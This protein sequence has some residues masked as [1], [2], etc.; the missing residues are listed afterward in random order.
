M[1]PVLCA[2]RRRREEVVQRKGLIHRKLMK[3]KE[4]SE[5]NQVMQ[6]RHETKLIFTFPTLP[7]FLRSRSTFILEK[8][9]KYRVAQSLD[10]EEEIFL[11]EF[12]SK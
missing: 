6:Y 2:W 4:E 12:R 11:E 9:S 8:K 1:C 10:P 3:L 7:L 5:L